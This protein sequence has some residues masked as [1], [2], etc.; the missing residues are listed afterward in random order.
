MATEIAGLR[1]PSDSSPRLS[2]EQ[3]Q[4]FSSPFA[5]NPLLVFTTNYKGSIDHSIVGEPADS[6]SW[7]IGKLPDCHRT[8]DCQGMFYRN[9]WARPVKLR[10]VKDGL[11]KTLMIGED[12]PRHNSHSAAYY[13]NGDWSAT[14]APL[15][16]KPNP[17]EPTNWP[18]VQGF[19]SDHPGGANFVFGDGAVRFISES[20]DIGLYQ[21]SSTRNGSEVLSSDF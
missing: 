18:D 8:V 3:F 16:Y 13:A 5:P 9:T 19:R 12:L 14:H 20:V 7:T 6:S 11:S 15:N 4:W 21:A 2:S 1:C 17:L 10:S